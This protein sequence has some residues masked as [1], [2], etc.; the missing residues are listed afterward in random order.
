M[1]GDQDWGRGR[2]GR[3][4]MGEGRG[5]CVSRFSVLDLYKWDS[6]GQMSQEELAE[7]GWST[8]ESSRLQIMVKMKL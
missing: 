8:G 5:E 6:H 7:Q 2:K 3:V 4:G 1:A